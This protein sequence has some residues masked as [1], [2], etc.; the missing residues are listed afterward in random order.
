MVKYRRLRIQGGIYFF[1][2]T[3][4]DRKSKLLITHVK[5]LTQAMREVQEKWAFKTIALVI[6][7]DHLHVVWQLPYDDNNF[8]IRWMKIKSKFTKSLIK[9]GIKIKKNHRGEYAL[10]QSR[11]WEHAIRDERDYENHVNYIHYNP[12]KHQLVKRVRDWPYSTFHKY[13]KNQIYQLNWGDTGYGGHD[14]D[15][16]EVIIS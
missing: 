10:W 2:A 7:P 9:A 12:V 5:L 13:V 8:S 15:G 6:L 11:F 4:R 16:G 14:I 3:L 1:T